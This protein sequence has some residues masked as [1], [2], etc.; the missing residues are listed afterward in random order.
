MKN[1]LLFIACALF[2]A[3]CIAQRPAQNPMSEK[4]YTPKKLG[5]KLVWKDEFKGNKLD[6]QKWALRGV[7]PRGIAYVSEEAVK[8][9][10]GYLKLYA[11]KKGDSLLGSA[12][13][14]QDLFMSKYG[15]YE[16]RAQLQKSP[17]VWAAFWIQ[18]TEISKGEDP[19][20][21]GAEIDILE[22][23]KKL[24]TDIVSHNVHWAYGPNQRTT[25]GMQSYL[26]GVSEGF[27]TFGLEWTPEKYIFYIDG[28][29]FYEVT[30]GISH[31]EEYMILSMEYPSKLEE[32]RNAVF[33]D[34]FIVDYVKVYQKRKK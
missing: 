25:R 12:V 31:I 20:I 2:T 30:Q 34:V 24:G 10:D 5:Y 15:Y 33:P 16:C 22:F 27:H 28:Y 21:F 26:K 6:P 18:S 19:A 9:E 32:I 17:G 7:G 14:T 23:F 29:K 1:V 13:G 4:R 11:L 8:V 3:T